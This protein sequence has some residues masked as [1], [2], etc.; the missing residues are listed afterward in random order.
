MDNRWTVEGGRERWWGGGG[1]GGERMQREMKE[2]ARYNKRALE[3]ERERGGDCGG[4][5]RAALSTGAA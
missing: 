4:L 3:R 2:G 1:G 5:N